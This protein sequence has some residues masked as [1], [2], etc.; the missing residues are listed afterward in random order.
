[1]QTPPKK[2]STALG[3]T[4]NDPSQSVKE[5][6]GVE[7]FK[8][9]LRRENPGVVTAVNRAAENLMTTLSPRMGFVRF[10]G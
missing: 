4:V 10:N 2:R 6:G 7:P 3:H 9:D 8:A 5:V 1:M